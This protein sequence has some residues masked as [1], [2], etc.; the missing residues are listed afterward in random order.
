MGL[1]FR[2]CINGHIFDVYLR[3]GWYVG[4]SLGV[5]YVHA[6]VQEV[7]GGRTAFTQLEEGNLS[8]CNKLF[9]TCIYIRYIRCCA[10]DDMCDFHFKVLIHG[11]Q[12]EAL[13][14]RTHWPTSG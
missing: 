11:E 6:G 9:G 4:A 2:Y 8:R 13:P 3:V 7:D 10:N 14:R 12:D 1:Q 5:E